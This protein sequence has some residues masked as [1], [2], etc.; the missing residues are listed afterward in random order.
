MLAVGDPL[1]AL[2]WGRDARA[3]PQSSGEAR[4]RA[5]RGGPDAYILGGIAGCDGGLVWKGKSEHEASLRSDLAG[6]NDFGRRP[7][8]LGTKRAKM[9][10]VMR[11][12][13]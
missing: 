10:E 9:I 5:G 7:A 4:Q 6:F 13:T 2:N 11:L 12:V 1:G 3:Q 8:S